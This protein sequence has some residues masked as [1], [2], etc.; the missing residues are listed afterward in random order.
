MLVLIF[1]HLGLLYRRGMEPQRGNYLFCTWLSTSMLVLRASTLPLCLYFSFSLSLCCLAF[2]LPLCL[3][4]S[5]IIS[6]R[7]RKTYFFACAILFVL[8]VSWLPLSL[9]LCL[10]RSENQPLQCSLFAQEYIE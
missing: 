6:T 5:E 1:R 8:W 10:C 7:R 9:C 2:S 3:C 4:H